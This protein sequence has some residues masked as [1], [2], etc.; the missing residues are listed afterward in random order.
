[1]GHRGFKRGTSR[2][3][4]I[5]RTVCPTCGKKGL[6]HPPL[7]GFE[8]DSNPL[9]DHSTAWCRYCETSHDWHT[10]ENKAPLFA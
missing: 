3:T 5:Q 10:M 1:M 8:R 2:R 4:Q 6:S 9:K 7:K